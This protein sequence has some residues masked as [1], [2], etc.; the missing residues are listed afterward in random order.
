MG[1]DHTAIIFYGCLIEDDRHEVD[2][3]LFDGDFSDVECFCLDAICGREPVIGSRLASVQYGTDTLPEL[4][5]EPIVEV[6]E[7]IEQLDLTP[8]E[9]PAWR[10][11]CRQW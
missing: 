6:D 11:A 2:E 5:D 3:A 9:E 1:V 10:I 7:A 8:T 4:P